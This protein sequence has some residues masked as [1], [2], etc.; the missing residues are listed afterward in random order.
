[1]RLVVVTGICVERDAISSAAVRQAELLSSLG[2]VNS[3][4]LVAQHHDRRP[5]SNVP[6]VIEADPWALATSPV[7]AE[8]DLVIFHWGI[9]YDLFNALI[10]IAE[11]RPTVVHFHNL[12]PRHL[13]E[14]SDWA[15]I[16]ESLRQIQLPLLTG[17]P[18]WTES[19]HNIDVLHDM[20]F[21]PDAVE[22]MPFPVEPLGRAWS[23]PAAEPDD[24]IRLLTVGRIVEAKG[25]HVLIEAIQ[26]V[27]QSTAR[28][29][30]VTIAG[31][32]GLSSDQYMERI[33][34]QIALNDLESTVRLR[35][36]LDDEK[37]WRE[38]LSADAVVV[39]SLH[40]GL[41]VPVLEA[42][43]AGCRVIASDAGN[44][45]HIVQPPDA[46]VPAD[47]P[48]ALAH[49]ILE[50]VRAEQASAEALSGRTNVQKLLHTYSSHGVEQ[51]LS[52]AIRRATAYRL[53]SG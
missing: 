50:F 45:P 41:C 17:T 25:L 24:P 42:Y 9:R 20:G 36:D 3:V 10:L 15:T 43:H 18:V 30:V 14:P 29:L 38:Y 51:H 11:Q 27:V 53:P 16:D 13:V 40:E 31:S 33:R 34:S 26:R 12:T 7:V 32:T 39:P 49:A 28:A 19:Q 22:F 23:R 47:D 5:S 4:H 37:L 8:S 21:G 35:L 52:E 2:G 1:M 6:Q 46:I 48:E 44:L